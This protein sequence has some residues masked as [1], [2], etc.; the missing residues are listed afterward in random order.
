MSVTSSGPLV[1]EQDDENDLRMIG[2]DGV[3]DGLQQHRLAGTRRG[4]DETALALAY[5]RQQIHDA[6]AN[7]FADGFHLHPLLGI[8]RREVVEQDFVARLFGRLEVDRLDLHQREIFLAFVRRPHVAVDGIAGFQVEF[9]NLRRGNIDVVGAGQ[10][11]VISGAEKAVAVRQN[12]QDAFSENVAFLFALRLKNPVNQ[13]LLAEAAGTGNF[14][15]AR[16]AA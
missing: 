10:I 14:Q 6:A 5:G 4:D 3:G 7:I 11:V 9:A 2:G 12:F 15:S 8:E 1:D 13:V 16:N